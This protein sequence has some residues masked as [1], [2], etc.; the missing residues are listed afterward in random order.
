[1]VGNQIKILLVEDELAHIELVMRSFRNEKEFSF[2][3]SK[4]LAEAKTFLSANKPDLLITDW[5]LPDGDAIELIPKE[6]TK[7]AYPII[8][9]TSYGNE[10]LAVDAIKAGALDFIVKSVDAFSKLPYTIKRALREWEHITSSK[11]A[12]D[13]LRRSEE[14]YRLLIEH[15]VDAIFIGDLK[16]NITGVNSKACEL[17]GYSKEE[18]MMMDMKEL[19]SAEELHSFPLQF[20]LLQ[21]GENI[22][23]TRQLKKKDGSF[24]P[25]EMNSKYMKEDYFQSFFRDISERFKSEALKRKIEETE[26]LMKVKSEFLANLSHEIRNPLN[27]I[28]GLT[29]ALTKTQLQELQKK[30]ISSIR[31]SSE[32]L[33]GILND[34]LDISKIEANKIEVNFEDFHFPTFIKELIIIYESKVIEQG[35]TISYTI[36]EEIPQNINTDLKKL[37]QI[38]AN[39][40]G[41]AIKFTSEGS[42]SLKAE[43]FKSN[44]RQFLRFSLSD[45]GIGIK[46]EDF[47]RIFQSFT[48][49]DSSTKKIYSGTG[50]GLS[51][52]KNYAELLGGT[53]SFESEYGKGSI[54]TLQI[55]FSNAEGKTISEKT[56]DDKKY[57]LPEYLRLLVVEDDAINRMYICNFLKSQGWMVDSASNGIEALE[58]WEKN[59]YNIILLDGQMPKMDGFETAQIIREKEESLPVKTPIIAITGYTINEKNEQ[60]VKA[61]INDYVIKPINE[62]DLLNKIAKLA[63]PRP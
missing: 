10:E 35:L 17:T 8:I 54:F 24:I 57:P 61:R 31:F 41:N 43:V 56:E 21:T 48:Q 15:A 63:V 5:R 52:S 46:K 33:M 12:E 37:K 14:K 47:P 51:I 62:T 28:V 42:I 7:I 26:Y 34:I 20:D 9:M 60:F 1:M 55:P 16:G 40:I 13:A 18:L 3:V 39:L 30:Y 32:N 50:L 11:I 53:V 2:T 4:S 44:S 23:N 22:I 36:S 19:F 59:S 25:V 38:L 6:K 49:L 58:K 27:A 29:N 45:T